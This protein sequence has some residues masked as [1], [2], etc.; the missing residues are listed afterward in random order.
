MFFAPTTAYEYSQAST[1]N[2]TA[3]RYFLAPN[4]PYG[5][6]LAYRVTSGTP[7]D[8]V[9]ILVTDIRGDTVRTLNGPGG[10]GLHQAFWDLR[11][12]AR[13]LGPAALRDSIV[14]AR[15]RR[16]SLRLVSEA[17]V[18]AVADS[19]AARGPEISSSPGTTWLP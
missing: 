3:N 8:S 10:I 15:V 17:G 7:R 19:S 16:P 2:F 11:T 14:A 9:K 5:A 4:P 13:P 18:E 1:Q 6:E 12:R